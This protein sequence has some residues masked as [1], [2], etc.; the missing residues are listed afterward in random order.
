MVPGQVERVTF[1]LQPISVMLRKGHRLRL[2]IAGADDGVLERVPAE[3]T[4]TL[5]I[6]RDPRSP[7]LLE[8]PVL[9]AA[10]R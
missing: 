3:G 4:P 9:R 7:S 8:L 2:A 6:H 10:P 1:R 5:T